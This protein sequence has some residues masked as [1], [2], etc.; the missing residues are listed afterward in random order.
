MT[1]SPGPVHVAAQ[2]G[3]VGLLRSMC[4][5]SLRQAV[6]AV[7]LWI[8]AHSIIQMYRLCNNVDLYLGALD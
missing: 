3:D 6:W 1:L 8:I 7:F 2:Q 4:A 5:E